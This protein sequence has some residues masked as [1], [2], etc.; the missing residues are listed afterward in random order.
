MRLER[1]DFSSAGDPIAGDLYLSDQAPKGVVVTTG[2]L[3]SVKEQAAG[4]YAK[5]MAER[6][7][8]ALAFDHRTFGESGGSPR[9]LENPQGKADDIVCAAI[10]LSERLGEQTPLF[11]LGICAGGGYMAEAVARGVGFRAFAGVAGVYPSLE[12]TKAWLSDNFDK[13]I[14]RAEAAEKTWK[15]TGEAETI[16]A[17][18]ADNGDV[19]MPL[20]EAFE[21]YGTARG[22]VPNYVNGFAVQSRLYT[23]SFDVQRRAPEIAIPTLIVHSENALAP[24]LARAFFAALRAE[25]E[26]LW[27]NSKGQIDFYDNPDLI[28]QAADRI[29]SFFDR[30]RSSVAVQ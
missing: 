25:K 24:A 17:V 6:G 27:V 10:A 2:P 3:T 18:A 22:G 19:A 29:A 30:A 26:D 23:L 5:A 8:A 1:F 21:Y 13:A 9:Q 14:K 12:Q 15:A 28:G 11:A 4:G 20:D 7:Y 16:P